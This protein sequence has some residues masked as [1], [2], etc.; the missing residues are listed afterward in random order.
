MR[1]LAALFGCGLLLNA[2]G[3]YETTFSTP[4]Q[5]SAQPRT[6]K[7]LF[8][9]DKSGHLPEARYRQIEKVMRDRG[10]DIE[11]VGNVAA[12]NA[13]TLARFDGLI[14]Y[15]NTPK[16][17]PEQEKDLLDYVEGGKGLIVLHCASFAFQ[18]SPKYIA[19]VG[20]HFKSQGMVTVKTVLRETYHPRMKGVQCFES[21]DEAYVHSKH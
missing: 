20:D 2:V 4:A 1:T 14:L 9:G 7:L 11:F 13:K 21:W 17:S 19:M 18:N 10:I 3:G 12:I 6:I 15:T 16:I 5:P 8:F